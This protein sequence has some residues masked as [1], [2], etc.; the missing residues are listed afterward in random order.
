MSLGWPA[1]A[2]L[3]VFPADDGGFR[4]KAVE[5]RAQA[6]G[7]RT[8]NPELIATME[9]LLRENYPL[10]TV[11]RRHSIAGGWE[12]FRD[13]DVLD[14]QLLLRMKAGDL[15]AAGRL[16]DRHASLVYSIAA[17]TTADGDLARTAVIDTFRASKAEPVDP[18]SVRVS[19]ARRARAIAVALARPPR[20]T[21]DDLGVLVVDLVTTHGLT[22]NQIGSILQR[23]R[24]EIAQLVNRML[25]SRARR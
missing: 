24:V 16:Y 9:A 22:A 20:E 15:G 18:G 11:L 23:D 17:R 19:M 14:I 21:T 3:V 13:G 6:A 25:S 7:R 4:K 10:A 2:D 8:L 1:A 5:S 12:V